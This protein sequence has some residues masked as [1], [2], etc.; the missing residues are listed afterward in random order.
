MRL[1]DADA[2]L[3]EV[4]ERYCKDCDKRKGIKNGK[5]R[6]IYEIGEA[7]CRAC[8]T[9]DMIDELEDAPTAEPQIVRCGECKYMR[10][11]GRTTLYYSCEIWECD[12]DATDYCS[13]GERRTDD[14]SHPFADD[15]MMGD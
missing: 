11:I 9:G 3:D 1:I 12:M 5:W 8:G 10:I 4:M 15:V 13:R 6:I 7:P 2:L 14:P